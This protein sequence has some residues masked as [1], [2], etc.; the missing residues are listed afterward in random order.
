MTKDQAILLGSVDIA[1]ALCRDD[2]LTDLEPQA[3]VDQFF[4]YLDTAVPALVAR[5]E[6]YGQEYSLN[7]TSTGV[8]ATEQEGQEAG[9]MGVVAKLL[10]PDVIAGGFKLIERLTK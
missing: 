8:G 3:A 10:T 6:Y 5:V 4:K 1:A 2:N 7:L 9:P